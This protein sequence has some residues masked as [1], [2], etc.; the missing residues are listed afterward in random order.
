MGTY[1]CA[2]V[3]FTNL[4]EGI[5]HHSQKQWEKDIREAEDGRL[6]NRSLM[7]ILGAKEVLVADRDTAVQ[8]SE[9]RDVC[10]D[11]V[12]DWLQLAINIEEKQ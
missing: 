2:N 1:Q 12:S 9:N 11:A 7:D 10:T 4:A 3:Y 8:Y 6:E 5:S